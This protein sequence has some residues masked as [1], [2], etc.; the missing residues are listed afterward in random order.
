M[1]VVW[2]WVVGLVLIGCTGDDSNP[3]PIDGGDDS[4]TAASSTAGNDAGTAQPDDDDDGETANVDTLGD[5]TAVGDETAGP[6][7]PTL[8][9]EVTEVGIVSGMPTGAAVYDLDDNGTDTLVVWQTATDLSTTDVHFIDLDVQSTVTLAGAFEALADFDGDGNLDA[10]MLD[11]PGMFTIYP[12]QGDGFDS[13]GTTVDFPGGDVAGAQDLDGDD[14][15][16]L[17]LRDSEVSLLVALNQGSAVFT[18][19]ATLGVPSQVRMDTHAAASDSSRFAVR[20]QPGPG[21]S[22]CNDNRF[23]TVVY[24][25]GDL[26]IVSGSAVGSWDSPIA[27]VDVS[28]EG[29]PDVFA[30][31]CDTIPSVTDLDLL[32]DDDSGTLVRTSVVDGVQWAAVADV[33]GDGTLDAVWGD[34]VDGEMLVRLDLAGAAL[35]ESTGVSAATVEHNAVYS[36]D[37]DDAGGQEIL[38]A[39]LQGADV[40]YDRIAAVDC[41]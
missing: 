32:T 40:R 34:E 27:V 39:V 20:S 2:A 26:T 14:N 41:R 22:G 19:D 31:A 13:D 11:S 1:R 37:L 29:N 38:R 12:G 16:D 30:V 35:T 6:G 4:G 3:P 10:L 5:E 25:A 17:L 9:W 21:D 7:D 36:A 24:D 23:D 8:C 15:A 33:D 28:G 18:A